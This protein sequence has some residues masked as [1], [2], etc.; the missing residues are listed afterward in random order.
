M[1]KVHHIDIWVND[2]DE[3]IKFYECLGF[4]I[5]QN[6]DEVGNKQIVLMKLDDILLEL[7]H[8]VLGD[9]SHNVA[10]CG[11]NKVFG[12]GV[13]DIYDAKSYLENTKKIKEKIII[14]TGILN[15]KYFL[16]KDPNGLIIEVIE[17]K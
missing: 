11:D 14:N 9:C 5:I 6:F 15:K 17:N 13:S 2:I 7:K 12:L 1:F 8:H 4:S 3:S 10:M 16:I